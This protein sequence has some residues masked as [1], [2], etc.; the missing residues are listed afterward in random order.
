[1][2]ENEKS[3]GGNKMKRTTIICISC[4]VTC[5]MFAGQSYAEINPDNVLGA[6]LLDE[7]A[8]SVTADAS[9]NG[10]DGRLM[11][12]PAWINGQFGK[13]LQF[14]GSSAY[15]DCG[16]SEAFNTD[17]FSVSFWCNIPATQTWNHIISK[18]QHA[19]SGTPG[20]VNWGVMMYDAQETILFETYNNTSW[21][22]ITADTTTSEWHHLVATYDG[23]TMQLYHDGQLASTAVAGI[24]LDPSR[25]LLIG[26]RSDAGSAGGFFNGSVDEVG[27]FNTV[28]ALEDIEAIMNDGL[29]GIIGQEFA[30]GPDPKN[31]S[32]HTDIWAT[33][34]WVA[35]NDAVS[36][37]VYFGENFDD[38]NDGTNQSET[39][40]GN[41][42]DDFFI[43]GIIGFPYPDGLVPGTTYYW[44]ID[45][46]NQDNPESPWKGNVWSFTVPSKKAYEPVPADGA[47][48]I[49]L[50]NL[51]L[52]WTKG[53]GTILNT[54]YIGDDYDTVANATDGTG[55]PLATYKPS[56][57]E[58]GKTYYWR[59][60]EYDG[61]ATYKGDV[62]SFKTMPDIPIS[63]PNLLGWWKLD[64]G[65]GVMA[66]DNSGHGNHG[67]LIRGPQWVAG[68]DGSAL[69]FDGVKTY[70]DCGND[71]AM[72]VSVFSTTFWCNIPNTQTWNHMV[73]KGSHGASGSPGSV[74]W[75]VMMVDA[76]QTILFETYNDTGWVGIRADTTL[77]EWHHVV[78]TYDGDIM[79][80]YHDGELAAS[81]TGAGILLDPSRSLTIGARSDAG[82]SAGA[83]F[84]GSIDDVRFYDKVLAQ[85][86]VIKAMQGDPTLA[87][88]PKPANGS[89]PDIDSAATLSWEPGI[90]ADQHDV[91]FGTDKDAVES[92]DAS[93]T[94][95]IYRGRQSGTSYTP[96]EGV[97]WGGGPYYWRIDEV[98]TDG[99]I[100]KGSI[101]SFTVADFLLIDDFEEYNAGE[102][103]IWYAWH[104]GLGYGVEGSDPYFPGNGTGS[105]VG[106]EN[107]ASYTEE[108]IIHGGFQS[109]PLFYDNNKQG[110]AKYSEAELTL[111]SPRDWTRQDV[112]ELSL[113]FR[114]YPA[115]TGSFVEA[116][117]G[118]Y[119]MT[120]SGTDI[121]YSADE[122]HF[123]FKTLTGAGSIIAQVF[124]VD[125]TDPW[126][127]AGVMFRESLDPDS[128]FAAV[129]ITPGNG[130]RF[131]ARIN[132]AVDATSDTTVASTEQIA[133]T[134]PYWV[135]LE[136][137][138][139]GNFRGYYS[140]NGSA[141]T[142]MTW[143][144]QY[145]TMSANVYI[146]LAVTS[147]NDSAICEAK[148][149]NVTF[150][151]NVTGQWM[152][153]DIGILSNDPEPLYVAVSNSTGAPAV[154]YNDDPAAAQV[155]T[156][157]EW[158]IPLSAFA[159]QGI[160]LTNVDKIAIGLGTRGNTTIAGGSGKMY[161]DDI[162]LYR[163]TE[164]Q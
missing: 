112:A 30:R 109:M 83:F 52:S 144:S 53:F 138:L 8:G 46:I 50:E 82:S 61:T 124:S 64:E 62:W 154:V 6:W 49:N 60:D 70:V 9:G 129:Y 153:Q 136:R 87:W 69:Q 73:S 90:K 113:W 106:D 22:G 107:T 1:M 35:G 130:C 158:V 57:L 56:G 142:P 58:P 55:V 5:L 132:T 75:G 146:G 99:T 47:N 26:A 36:H 102:N 159:D 141:W 152:N 91:Y 115:V 88:N 86:E 78:A 127:K 95:G 123:A 7:G 19:A 121:W 140:A 164:G 137:D 37:D 40:Q 29:I 74:N 34:T 2:G 116:P 161:I 41:V 48:F 54:V 128:K 97:E 44:R 31:G 100:S 110:Y 13:A 63:D 3:D 38:V 89:T 66:I 12:S 114:G 42:G 77:G 4:I 10:N 32:I 145:I 43:V 162:R 67:T 122:F 92:A 76:A 119:T 20:S 160:N 163:D 118:T 157:T 28:I 84:N 39:F 72:N 23:A 103:Q 80:L 111:T 134:A 45:E 25:P 156:W 79:Q 139:G 96:P 18:G 59:I 85:D 24:L 148:F 81:T 104:D 14:N 65:S 155:D 94:S 117:A 68:Q 126:A 21:R 16:N 98:N 125:N 120:A 101:W 108:T 11:G 17:V 15:V 131:Q 71:E 151:G 147:H 135:K 27:F 105:A 149:S 143:N 93:D 133:I 51:T 33:L 150:A